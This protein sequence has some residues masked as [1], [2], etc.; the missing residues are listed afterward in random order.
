MN[1]PNAQ[2]AEDQD[3]YALQNLDK[4]QFFSFT[5]NDQEY[6]V[7]I[8]R[9]QEI[10]GWTPVRAMPGLPDF[11]KGVIDLRGDVV[12]VI[13]FRERLGMPSIEYTSLNVVVIM[14]VKS[15]TGDKIYGLVVD[16]V[17]EVYDAD[18]SQ[19]QQTPDM[20]TGTN[21]SFI[22]SLL[23]VDDRMVIIL[24]VDD[25]FTSDFPVKQKQK[26]EKKNTASDN[27]STS[28]QLNDCQLLESSFKLLTPKGNQLVA[29]FYSELFKR[30]PE[31]KP[32]FDNTSISEQEKKL[33]DSLQLLVQNSRHPEKLAEPLKALGAKHTGWG[34]TDE[35]YD[36]V[37]NVLLDVMQELA[38]DQWN[39]EIRNA[40]VNTLTMVKEL[41]TSP[42]ESSEDDIELSPVEILE[43]SF[44]L[45]APEA[46]ELVT[47][48]YA[49]LF[50]DYPETRKMFSNTS[51]AV[52]KPKLIAA[53]QLVIASLRKPDELEQ[54][55]TK[56][57][58]KHQAYG[59]EPEHYDAVASTLLTVMAELAGDKWND[60]LQS[61]WSSALGTIKDTMLKGYDAG[62]SPRQV[63]L[64][65]NSFELLV[66]KA[67]ELVAKFYGHLFRTNPAI[68]ALFKDIN[69]KEQ[70]KKLIA[71]LQMIVRN[72]H[73]PKKLKYLMLSL[74][75]RHQNY[76]AAI[77]HYDSVTKSLINVLEDMAG[78][79]WTNDTH[80]AWELALSIVKDMML[81]GYE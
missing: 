11:I 45:L 1:Q 52:Q 14:R 64:I 26:K 63:A 15:K 4:Q 12:P 71:G 36:I 76:G 27:Q 42:V 68:K 80:D 6:A 66:P 50:K 39:R 43:T 57:G 61:T 53:L 19:M 9:I 35:H 25:F 10:R 67:D 28:Q 17:S 60:T 54:A 20:G 81:D 22:D 32:M 21:T 24:N 49:R 8:L 73:N 29:K 69:P 77:G 72:L 40:W 2:S 41:M 38:G 18:P 47:R 56:L 34:V 74:G 55:L 3:S 44:A 70:K 30:H 65:E 78:A 16:A 31:V 62:L 79:H 51:M 46:E 48:F 5:S 33:L 23:T 75:K 13:D 7:D 59:A 58:K 37:A